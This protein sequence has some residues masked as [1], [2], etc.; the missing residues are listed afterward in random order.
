MS[1]DEGNYNGVESYP[2]PECA[3]GSMTK[4]D[5]GHWEC[6]E[7]GLVYLPALPPPPVFKGGE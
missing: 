5:V 1:F 2:C 4:T 6:D 3:A 7:C